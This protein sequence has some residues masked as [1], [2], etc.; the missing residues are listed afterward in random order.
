[1]LLPAPTLARNAFGSKEPL[2]L[3]AMTHLQL[4]FLRSVAALSPA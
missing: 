3:A 2:L 4:S 1:M